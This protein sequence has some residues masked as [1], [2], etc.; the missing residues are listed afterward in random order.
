M[1]RMAVTTL[2]RAP[3]LPFGHRYGAS[4]RAIS[5]LDRCLGLTWVAMEDDGEMERTCL[6]PR[7]WHGAAGIPRIRTE[8][9][10]PG[11]CPGFPRCARRSVSR[12]RGWSG[13]DWQ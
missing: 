8:P 5:T 9:G 11:G 4:D 2:T 3:R 13:P 7:M 10:C 12:F 1:N 6:M